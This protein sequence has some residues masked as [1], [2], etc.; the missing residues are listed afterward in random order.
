MGD[1]QLKLGGSMFSVVRELHYAN[2]NAKQ[3][4]AVA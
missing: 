4:E 2:H 1:L 3:T